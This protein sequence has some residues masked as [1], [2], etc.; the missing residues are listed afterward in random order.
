MYVEPLPFGALRFRELL[1]QSRSQAEAVGEELDMGAQ[2][3]QVLNNGLDV[4]P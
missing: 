2:A 1:D 4:G 3:A